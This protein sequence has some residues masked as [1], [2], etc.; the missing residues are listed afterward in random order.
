LE[1]LTKYSF[2]LFHQKV[3]IKGREKD[4]EA[5]SGERNMAPEMMFPEVKKKRKQ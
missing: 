5:Y 2:V 4:E 3:K 1:G